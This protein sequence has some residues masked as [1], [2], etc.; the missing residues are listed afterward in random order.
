[1]LKD[2]VDYS[3]SGIFNNAN[4]LR[5]FY[6]RIPQSD[7]LV[8]Q[9]Q[10]KELSLEFDLKESSTFSE[11][12]TQQV[13]FRLEKLIVDDPQI[14]I[15]DGNVEEKKKTLVKFINLHQ[16]HLQDLQ[17]CARI[18]SRYLKGFLIN[19]KNLQLLKLSLHEDFEVD[20]ELFS[21]LKASNSGVKELELNLNDSIN[22]KW[23]TQLLEKFIECFPNIVV[24]QVEF[25]K[26]NSE[27]HKLKVIN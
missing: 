18:E 20:P 16:N 11:D 12:F 6:C 5:K 9:N 23:T 21:E 13:K 22:D 10:L 26:V 8:K 3:D 27:E 2:L 4:N 14:S 25:G 15:D 24:L 7:F 1:M 19:L 17:I